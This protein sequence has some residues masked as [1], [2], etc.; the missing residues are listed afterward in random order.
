[1]LSFEGNKFAGAAAIGEKLRSLPFQQCKHHITTIDAQP[2]PATAAGQ[3][4]LV[5]ISGN[6]ELPGE[7]H[8][9]K[10]SQAFH[11]LPAAGSFFVFNDIF[12]LNYG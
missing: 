1:M 7:A 10:F 8:M 11:L 6:I 3:G 2:T 4:I 5:F 9:T 12:R